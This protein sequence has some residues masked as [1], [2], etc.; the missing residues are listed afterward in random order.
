M[1]RSPRRGR[2]SQPPQPGPPQGQGQGSYGPPPPYQGPQWQQP[3]QQQ[4]QNQPQWQNQAPPPQQQGW[5]QQPVQDQGYQ[6]Q[7]YYGGD[8]DDVSEAASLPLAPIYRRAGARLLD[9]ALVAVFGFALVLP[10]VIGTI[11][12][13]SAGSKTDTE[14]G[15]WNWPIIFTLFAVLSVLP[16]IYEAVQLSLWGRTL[17][18]RM[19]HLGVV[20]VRPAGDALT[21]TQAVWRAGII[22]VGYLIGGFFFLV[23]AVMVWD[24]LAYGM[25]LVWIGALMA[26]LWAIWDQPLH[27]SLHDRF[28]GTLVIDE[29]VEDGDAGYDEYSEYRE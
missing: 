8:Q 11:G 17:G 20:Q 10:I 9:N 13:D 2:H 4:W 27:Q 28:A 1:S 18:K 29:R 24:Y 7:G 12:L 26:Y 21:T 5:Q 25:L 22:H 3:Q 6:D 19:L 16:F 15:I 14:G 23:L